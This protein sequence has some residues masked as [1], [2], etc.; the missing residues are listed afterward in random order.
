MSGEDVLFVFGKTVPEARY[1]N[2]LLAQEGRWDGE[3]GRE[4]TESSVGLG[5]NH[6][7]INTYGEDP[8]NAWFYMIVS[9][10]A[11][12]ANSLKNYLINQGAPEEAI[13]TYLFHRDFANGYLGENADTLRFQ[14]RMSCS[15]PQVVDPYIANA[16]LG[17]YMFRSNPMAVGDVVEMEEW[18]PRQDTAELDD[19][20]DM[21]TLVTEIITQ[22]WAQYEA[23]FL[24]NFETLFHLDP[25]RCRGVPPE[26]DHCHYDNPDALYVEFVWYDMG[27]IPFVLDDNDFIILVGANHGL[28]ELETYFAYFFTRGSDY[29]GFSGFQDEETI[30]SAQQ[31]WPEAGDRFFAYKIA[32]NCNGE[33]WCL[34]LPTGP[35]GLSPGEE[36]FINGRIYLDPVSLTG[37]D[38]A[39]FLPSVV[40]WYKNEPKK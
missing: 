11:G 30:G 36:F 28:Y 6:L 21:V 34:E 26:P 32:M 16:P 4:L 27:L 5:I 17:V 33:P 14:L 3:E 15:D 9:A 19:E 40:I 18:V 7:T 39:N 10:S 12:A 35:E 23:P 20:E 38:P 25:E 2:F 37:P 8:Y 13:N 29:Y 1:F 24:S 22:N 31:Y